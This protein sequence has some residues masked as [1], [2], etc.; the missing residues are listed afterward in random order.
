MPSFFLVKT[1]RRLLCQASCCIA[2][3]DEFIAIVWRSQLP[4][5]GLPSTQSEQSREHATVIAFEGIV[6]FGDGEV[7]LSKMRLHQG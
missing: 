6:V 2:R 1:E 7:C 5:L 3:R 4:T